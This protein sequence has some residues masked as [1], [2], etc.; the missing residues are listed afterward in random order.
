M[1]SSRRRSSGER[2]G[3]HGHSMRFRSFHSVRRPLS[4]PA[5]FEDNWL[6]SRLARPG[7]DCACRSPRR[8]GGRK[9][10]RIHRREL[11]RRRKSA[12][13]AGNPSASG[14]AKIRVVG[15]DEQQTMPRIRSCG[16][17]RSRLRTFCSTLPSIS[18]YPCRWLP[19][20]RMRRS[21]WHSAIVDQRSSSIGPL[22][23][24]MTAG[25]HVRCRLRLQR[26]RPC[27]E[28]RREPPCG[29]RD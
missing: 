14:I 29:S 28:F 13:A 10:H 2:S 5:A 23:V 11:F 27:A 18:P 20:C 12:S 16:Q 22:A 24:A 17:R 25:W 21:G 9:D 26:S 8:A 1:V 15:S 6:C 4:T 19:S 3:H 7:R